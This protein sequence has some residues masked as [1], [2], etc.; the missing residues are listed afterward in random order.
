MRMRRL[1]EEEREWRREERE[2]WRWDKEWKRGR[3]WS[4]K[5]EDGLGGGVEKGGKG[6]WWMWRV[7]REEEGQP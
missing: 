1:E 7:E 5:M 2:G 4:G 6:R 3:R